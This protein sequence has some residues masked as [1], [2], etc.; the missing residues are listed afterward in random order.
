MPEHFQ[1]NLVD[2]GGFC[3]A[4]N[5]NPELALRRGECRF[6]VAA[7][8]VVGEKFLAPKEGVRIKIRTW[9]NSGVRLSS[10]DESAISVLA[11]AETSRGLMVFPSNS[12]SFGSPAVHVAIRLSSEQKQRLGSN[13][14]R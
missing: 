13:V 3:P 11:R 1:Q 2:L 10:P 5:E 4:P 8:M 6:H 14:C 9:R 7:L 12:G